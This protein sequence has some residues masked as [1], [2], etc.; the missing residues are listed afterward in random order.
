MSIPSIYNTIG[1]ES[2]NQLGSLPDALSC[3]VTEER[4]GEFYCE[5]TYPA[6]GKDA[7]KIKVG[8]IIT[9]KARMYGGDQPFRIASIEKHLDGTMDVTA[10]HLIDDILPDIF[11]FELAFLLSNQYLKK[12]IHQYVAKL[13][14]NIC[15]VVSVNGIKQLG[16]LSSQMA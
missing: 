15:G 4:N 12:N 8:N 5:L 1:T 10:Y 14:A 7:D 6:G 11:K 2:Y 16:S 13:I 3:K 9:A